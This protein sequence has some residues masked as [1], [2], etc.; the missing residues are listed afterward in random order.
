[1]N[2]LIQKHRFDDKSYVLKER[3]NGEIFPQINDK[4]IGS[5]IEGIMVKRIF[6]KGEIYFEIGGHIYAGPEKL[7]EGEIKLY[8]DRGCEIVNDNERIRWVI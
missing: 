5:A 8:T 6:F 4:V 1:M 3:F 2:W 7:W